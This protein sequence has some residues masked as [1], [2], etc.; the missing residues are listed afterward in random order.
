M[1]RKRKVCVH[2]GLPK[3][4]TTTLQKQIFPVI[5]DDRISYLGRNTELEKQVIQLRRFFVSSGINL[6]LKGSFK[7]GG[8]LVSDENIC[9]TPEHPW[10]AEGVTPPEVLAVNISRFSQLVSE[11]AIPS[12]LITIRRQDQWFA[13]RYAESAKIM[14][15]P[16]QEDFERRVKSIFLHSGQSQFDRL[17]WLHFDYLRQVFNICVGDEM[18]FVPQEFLAESPVE[19]TDKI[20][21]FLEIDDHSVNECSDEDDWVNSLSIKGGKWRLK[22]HSDRSIGLTNELS[23]IIMEP[24]RVGNEKLALVIDLDLSK[25]GYF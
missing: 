10:K 3:T 14:N 19:W 21:D 6:N 4:A 16:S 5:A 23:E 15:N 24:F 18:L 11:D 25:Y 13:S 17:R 20:A 7:H 12:S 9:M 2:P 8:V 22:G 1:A